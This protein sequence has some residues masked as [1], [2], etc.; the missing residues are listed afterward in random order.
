MRT[1][2]SNN[3]TREITKNYHNS[4]PNRKIH[5]KILSYGFNNIDTGYTTNMF[6]CFDPNHELVGFAVHYGSK[7]IL[8]FYNHEGEDMGLETEM[9]YKPINTP[10]VVKKYR[11]KSNIRQK[12]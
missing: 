12:K 3:I 5:I 1:F 4:F 8:R 7:K 6:F 10:K 11:S 2:N 9:I